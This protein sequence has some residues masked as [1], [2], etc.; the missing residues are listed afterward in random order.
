MDNNDKEKE[1]TLKY[2]GQRDP[3]KQRIEEYNRAMKRVKIS[4]IISIVC[5]SIGTTLSLISIILSIIQV[6]G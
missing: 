1:S 2:I 3:Y 4:L 6:V 5:A